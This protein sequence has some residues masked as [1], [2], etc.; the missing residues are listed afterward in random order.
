MSSG[1]ILGLT[2]E[3]LQENNWSVLANTFGMSWPPRAQNPPGHTGKSKIPS[4]GAGEQILLL[5]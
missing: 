1:N 2:K 3:H 4:Q 5:K